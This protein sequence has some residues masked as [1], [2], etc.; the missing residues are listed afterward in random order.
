ML[1]LKNTWWKL[2][3]LLKQ[4]H[5]ILI[6]ILPIILSA[7]MCIRSG[8][9]DVSRFTDELFQILCIKSAHRRSTTNY[10]VSQNVYQEWD[11]F[12]CFKVTYELF[13]MLCTK[14]YLT[15]MITVKF[16]KKNIFHL[17]LYLSNFVIETNNKTHSLLCVTPE[18][19]IYKKCI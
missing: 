5:K 8:I 4:L 17:V 18:N 12:L 2:Q 3:Y 7:K 13:Q 19:K 16:T 10:F 11:I 6:V 1:A 14:K 15:K 9:F